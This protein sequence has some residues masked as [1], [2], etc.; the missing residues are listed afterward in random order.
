V[1]AKAGQLCVADAS[2]AQKEL[3]RAVERFET[4]EEETLL[5][6]LN[7]HADRTKSPKRRTGPK[8]QRS[9]R[10]IPKSSLPSTVRIDIARGIHF[11]NASSEH[12]TVT[13]NKSS[14]TSK[15]KCGIVDMN[16]EKYSFAL[17]C[18]KLELN[19]IGYDFPVPVAY[20]HSHSN[21]DLRHSEDWINVTDFSTAVHAEMV[22]HIG[23][24]EQTCF[25]SKGATAKAMACFLRGIGWVPHYTT[26]NVHGDTHTKK[27]RVTVYKRSTA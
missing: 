26:R 3:L 10:N 27:E 5:R 9:K 2:V 16:D 11:S 8:K 22:K 23:A 17:T 6:T 13:S 19:Y 4:E 25:P 12:D 24:G 21:P 18:L 1:L 7:G 14:T 15:S 20:E